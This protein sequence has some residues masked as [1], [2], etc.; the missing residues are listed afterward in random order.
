MADKKGRVHA[1]I[2]KNL[3]EIIIHQLKD[4]ITE[5]ASIT[6]VDVTSDYSYCNV[7][8]SHLDSTRIDELAQYLNKRKGFIR[9]RLAAT[10]DIFKT[11]DL[12]F[13]ADKGYDKMAEMD[14]LIDNAIH[15]KP[16][17]LK[18]VYG[19]NYKTPEQKEAE[20][21]RRAERK[22]LKEAQEKKTKK[23]TRTTKKKQA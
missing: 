21:Q 20:K 23:T 16:K 3:S 2:Q 17:T 14:A 1:I 11:P 5:F 7:Y 13:H 8:V 6:H 19:K 18:D 22:A 4:P 9:T 15:K 12:I 10:L